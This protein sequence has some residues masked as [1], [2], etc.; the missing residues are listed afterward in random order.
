MN[1]DD[2]R[3]RSEKL[4]FMPQHQVRW[5]SPGQLWRAA[6]KVA[7]ATVFA[8]YSDKRELQGVLPG[9]TLRAPLDDFEK[10]DELW[11]D[12]VADTGDGFDSTFT[13]ASLL[14]QEELSVTSANGTRSTQP[15]VRLPRGS[16]LVLGG[17]E[18][19]P[20][21]SA[22]AYEDRTKGP[23]RAALPSAEDSPLLLAL[24]GNHDWYDGLSSFLRMFTQMR[25][26]GGWQTRQRRSY[27]AVQLP[28]RWWLIGL[29]SQ[30][31]SFIDAPQLEFFATKVSAHLQQGD[32][33]ILCA[34]VP[35]WV[36]TAEED[37]DAFNSLYWFERN[38]VR[39]RIDDITGE[40]I[41]TGAATRLW[42]SGD[43]HHYARYTET[44]EPEAP[45]AAA[46]QMITCG[47]G[48]AYLSAT[49][50]LPKRLVLPPE[51]S[52]LRDKET[53]G[54]Q[55]VAAQETYPA[56][57][58]SRRM[59]RDIANPFAG[60]WLPRRNP[61]F[62]SLA[63]GLHIVAFFGLSYILAQ[64]QGRSTLDA[65]RR[66]SSIEATVFGLKALLVLTLCGVLVWGNRV[67]R[68]KEFRRPSSASAAVLLQL[69]VA[70]FFLVAITALPLPRQGA[71][72]G[73]LLAVV[74]AAW[75][76]GW[77]LGSEAFA[78]YVLIARSGQV[79][80]WQMA[81]QSIEDHKGFVRMHLDSKGRLTLY[82]LVIDT[83]CR[84]WTTV[85]DLDHIGENPSPAV[86]LPIPRLIE[87]PVTITREGISR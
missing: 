71:G 70:L 11:I 12:F 39:T 38:I 24:P 41:P 23:F 20:L 74:P 76:T 9:D 29:D 14:A 43:S 46:Q 64:T 82:P 32:A 73:L 56:R 4:G 65:L 49:H 69:V 62:G 78:L 7:F 28:N 72:W 51:S 17:D 2:L 3:R 81:G 36:H 18:V 54:L 25:S 34:A 8:E 16:V 57:N 48:G 66:T 35:A 60:G 86:T 42:I 13:V 15:S 61:G 87:P 84:E 1:I 33:V 37:S 77:V 63:G 22:K 19:Y 47:L 83:V 67:R 85:P 80:G 52:H 21:A 53:P 59:A 50:R 79:A 5:L 45:E 58:D 40:R 44:L 30:L 55:F 68:E 26:I 75:I 10:A 31:G 6:A 27:F